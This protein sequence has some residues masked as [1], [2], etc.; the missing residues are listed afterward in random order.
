MNLDVMRAVSNQEYGG[1]YKLNA[2]LENFNFA[3]LTHRG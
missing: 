1:N 2:V 3:H